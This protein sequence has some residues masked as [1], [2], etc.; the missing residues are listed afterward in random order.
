MTRSHSPAETRAPSGP[1][2]A[3]EFEARRLSD[4]V[5][6]LTEAEVHVW[7]LPY[8]RAQ[9]RA[10]LRLLLGTYLGIDAKQ[11][12]L[13][14][15]VHGRP[16]LPSPPTF[17]FNW[18]HSGDHAL[19]A[20]ARALPQLGVDLERARPRARAMDLARRFFNPH[21]SNWL[22]TL[23]PSQQERAFLRLWTAK[24]AVLKG[25]GRGLAY[26]L[27]RVIFD[28]SGPHLRALHFDGDAGPSTDWQLHALDPD[29]TLL[30]SL[31]WRGKPRDLR[32]FRDNGPVLDQAV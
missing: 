31:A 25:I 11:V 16:A 19:I 23:P 24:E 26:G 17:D 7:L 22:D 32:L 9:G 12:L 1:V 21:E 6:T 20:L 14:D 4:G 8:Q 27:D 13:V 29:R 10:V 15:D 18:S 2:T 28:I 30:G 3:G 5:P